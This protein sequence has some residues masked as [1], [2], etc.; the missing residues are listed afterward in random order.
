MW[1]GHALHV[2]L[3]HFIRTNSKNAHCLYS[4]HP[5]IPLVYNSNGAG[6]KV[7][8]QAAFLFPSRFEIE[9]NGL[10]MNYPLK[11]APTGAT[12]TDIPFNKACLL[13]N[14]MVYIMECL[15][16]GHLAGNG[17]FTKKCEQYFE[18]RFGIAKALMTTSCTDALEMSAILMDLQPGDEVI[19]P[20][21]T[22]VSTANAFL[23]RGANIVFADSEADT[24]N[25]DVHKLEALITDK[26]KAIVIVHY[27]GMACHMDALLELTRRHNLFL[28]EDAAHAIDAYYKGKPLGTF[29]H[30]ATFSFHETKNIICGE[31]GLLAINDP[32]LIERA[33][34]IR[35]KGTN[36]LAFFRGQVDKYT[37][38][39][40]GSSFLPADYVAAFLW[41]QLENMEK[42]QARRLEIWQ[43]YYELLKPLEEKGLLQLPHLPQGASNNAH[44]FYL[45]CQS[46]EQ[47]SHIIDTLK[48]DKVQAV[49]HYLPLH[50]SPYY[51]PRHDGRAL[52]NVMRY[53]DC[54]LRLPLFFELSAEQVSRVAKLVIAACVSYEMSGPE[55]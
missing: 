19:M 55:R 23:L 48:K 30:L 3:S 39:D 32:A 13:G 28:V 20:S 31:G 14:E 9:R 11:P 41:A 47:R 52:P 17:A 27:A 26:T 5:H 49:F 6:K 33:E 8:S 29:G 53:A 45:V 46:L 12:T 36:R 35:E 38:Q 24:P 40:I 16:Q 44:M 18:Q 34:I 54:L 43:Q 7:A 37:W 22:F 1:E 21:Y 50:D 2:E 4:K 51:Q 42:I 10:A 25:I 15:D